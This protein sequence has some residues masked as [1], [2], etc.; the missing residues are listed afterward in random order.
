MQHAV[1]AH[2]IKIVFILWS[3]CWRKC[4]FMIWSVFFSE[5]MMPGRVRNNMHSTEKRQTYGLI[6]CNWLLNYPI[7][8]SIKYTLQKPFI[9][10]PQLPSTVSDC[11]KRSSIL[12]SWAASFCNGNFSMLSTKT[13]GNEGEDY[14]NPYARHFSN[15]YNS[16]FAICLN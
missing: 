3:V 5:W 13:G 8:C 15:S 10:G 1:S 2:V 12:W 4:F 16:Y 14:F 6:K 11:S 9:A 7:V